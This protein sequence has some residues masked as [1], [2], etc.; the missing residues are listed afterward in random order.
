MKTGH[1]KIFCLLSDISMTLNGMVAVLSLAESQKWTPS[2]EQELKLVLLLFSDLISFGEMLIKSDKII[3]IDPLNPS[4]GHTT[5]SA[6]KRLRRVILSCFQFIDQNVQ[7]NHVADNTQN[8]SSN[9]N[10]K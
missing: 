3:P 4:K 9:F 2:C 7:V 1:E 8:K 6:I 5:N 10:L